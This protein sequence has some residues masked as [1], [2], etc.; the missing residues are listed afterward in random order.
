M[1]SSALYTV[2]LFLG[3]EAFVTG[4]NIRDMHKA[5][6]DLF[7]MRIMDLAHIGV[8]VKYVAME[9][10]CRY[11]EEFLLPRLGLTNLVRKDK[12]KFYFDNYSPKV[13]Y[14]DSKYA[15]SL[16]DIYI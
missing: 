8:K 1:V 4:Y 16:E 12:S 14:K 11:D 6:E 2:N 15:K 5:V 9:S 3:G 10:C 13:V 7:Q